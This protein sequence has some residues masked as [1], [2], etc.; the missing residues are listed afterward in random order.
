MIRI[1]KLNIARA[2]NRMKQYADHHRSDRSFSIGDWVWLKLQPYRQ[3]TAKGPPSNEKLSSKFYGP[4]QVQEVIGTVAYRLK[5]PTEEQ[6]HPIFHVSQLKPFRGTLLMIA[7]IPPWFQGKAPNDIPQP[8]AI[9]NTRI[10]K[11]HNVAQVQYL[12]QW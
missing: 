4:F 6:I 1:L 3:I 7:H 12:V 11:H 9:L 5:L 10:V 2:Q 8:A